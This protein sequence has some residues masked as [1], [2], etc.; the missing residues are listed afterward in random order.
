MDVSGVD[1]AKFDDAYFKKNAKAKKTDF[2]EDEASSG[3]VRA[4]AERKADQKALDKPILA[5]IKK[6]DLLEK[7]LAKPF[8]LSNGEYPHKMVF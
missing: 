1:T 8:S 2:T 7:Y 6:V 3:K 5:A 4:D